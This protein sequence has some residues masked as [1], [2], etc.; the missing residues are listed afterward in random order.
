[1][2]FI[3]FCIWVKLSQH[4][5]GSLGQCDPKAEQG[6]ISLSNFAVEDKSS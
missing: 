5:D 6:L 2:L 3:W 4:N 1:M